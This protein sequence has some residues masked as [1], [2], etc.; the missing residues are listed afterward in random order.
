[1]QERKEHFGHILFFYNR[2]GY[3]SGKKKDWFSKFLSNNFD[4]KDAS[5]KDTK[6]RSK[7]TNNNWKN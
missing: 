6:D 2:K 1:M 5:N 3:C 4:I 7:S